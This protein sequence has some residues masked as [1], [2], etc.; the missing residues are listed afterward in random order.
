MSWVAFSDFVSV[1][2]STPGIALIASSVLLNATI[3][4]TSPWTVVWARCNLGNSR[5]LSACSIATKT[6][7]VFLALSLRPF[8]RRSMSAIPS[9]AS[10]RSVFDPIEAVAHRLQHLLGAGQQVHGDA[11]QTI[12]DDPRAD[13]PADAKHDAD[14]AQNDNDNGKNTLSCAHNHLRKTYQNAVQPK[15]F[16]RPDCVHDISRDNPGRTLQRSARGD[17][18]AGCL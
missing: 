3:D 10:C 9:R 12:L 2:T 14:D 15:S 1:G 11:G 18:L 6:R 4:S 5:S 7:L 17:A 16:I 13:D 8:A